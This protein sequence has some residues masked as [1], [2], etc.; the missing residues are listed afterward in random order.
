MKK[1]LSDARLPDAIT[2]SG[3]LIGVSSEGTAGSYRV[4]YELKGEIA[5]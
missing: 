2:P 5:V 1:A 4:A 3:Y